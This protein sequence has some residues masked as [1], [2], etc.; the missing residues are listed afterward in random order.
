MCIVDSGSPAPARLD[1]IDGRGATIC[2]NAALDPGASVTL[3]HPRAGE[4]AAKVRDC[5]AQQIRLDFA[6]DA[7]GVGFAMAAI[8]AD[9]L[10]QG[11]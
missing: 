5:D 9:L 3:S 8:A 7:R 1:A 2:T 6:S 11:A 4:I 10:P